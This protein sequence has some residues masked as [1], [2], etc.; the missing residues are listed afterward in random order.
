[1]ASST[2]AVAPIQHR[3]LRQAD[4]RLWSRKGRASRRH[5][6]AGLRWGPPD[7]FGVEA[8]TAAVALAWP[9][10]TGPRTSKVACASVQVVRACAL[11]VSAAA[12]SQ[13]RPG[14]LFHGVDLGGSLGSSAG[15]PAPRL[16]QA[17]L[18]VIELLKAATSEH[19]DRRRFADP[20]KFQE[21]GRRPFRATRSLRAWITSP[22]GLLVDAPHH[23]RDVLDL[24]GRARAP[25]PATP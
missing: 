20:E 1:M 5:T 15:T 18:L 19:H 9:K 14:P 13:C 12:P 3:R 4:R 25:Y 21:P 7:G 6:D 22:S 24:L 10:G 2:D 8:M 16:R 23:R 17:L 11:N